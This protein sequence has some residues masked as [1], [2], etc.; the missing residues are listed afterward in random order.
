MADKTVKCRTCNGDHWT[1][2]CPFKETGYIQNK[3]PTTPAV[4]DKRPGGPSAV[5]DKGI[6]NF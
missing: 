4:D 3:T 1:L 5:D 2:K 6:F